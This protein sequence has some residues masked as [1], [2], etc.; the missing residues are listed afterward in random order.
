MK[1]FRVS[2]TLSQQHFM[3]IYE[4]TM[5]FTEKAPT[6]EQFFSV[7]SFWRWFQ[8]HV[9]GWLCANFLTTRPLREKKFMA[10]SLDVFS[11][12]FRGVLLIPFPLRGRNKFFHSFFLPNHSNS[13]FLKSFMKNRCHGCY[14]GNKVWENL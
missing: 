1:I 10:L 8:Y 14:E 13:L 4:S 12:V 11:V 2:Q 6:W 3:W 5:K 7:I 9:T